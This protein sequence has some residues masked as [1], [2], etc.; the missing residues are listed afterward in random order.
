MSSALFQRLA[1]NT[2]MMSKSGI[3]SY[4]KH[5]NLKSIGYKRRII[6][7]STCRIHSVNFKHGSTIRTVITK[8]KLIDFATLLV[9]SSSINFYLKIAVIDCLSSFQIYKLH[10]KTKGI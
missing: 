7:W 8:K 3:A 1:L 2:M 6:L 10:K 9:H 4:K 5:I